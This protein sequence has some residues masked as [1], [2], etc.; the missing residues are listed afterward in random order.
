MIPCPQCGRANA[1]TAT[2]CGICRALLSP[3]KLSPKPP[4]V[5]LR[6]V[7]ADGGPEAVVVMR[8]EQLRCGKRGDLAFADDP[9]VADIQMKLFFSGGHLAVQDVGGGNG[10]FL[11]LR[12]ARELS[13]KGELRVG[14]QRLILEPLPPARPGPGGTLA[15][16]S[17]DD[18][19]TFRLLQRYEGG[20]VGNA[21][22][23]KPGTTT[24]GR[25]AGDITFPQD[26]FVS[27]RHAALDVKEGHVMVRDLG[28]SNGTF[29]RLTSPTRVA[30]GDQFLVGRQLVRVEIRG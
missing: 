21:F 16:G 2:T 11:R 19:A 9:F 23:L 25:E 30:S 4:A 17:P 14:R 8:G 7:R 6:V 1:A 12:D 18:G 24:I 27:G 3:P 20:V 26:G 13:P 22:M 28:S 15:W 29:V 5:S 10:T